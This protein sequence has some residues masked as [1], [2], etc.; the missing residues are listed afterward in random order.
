MQRKVQT[1]ITIGHAMFSAARDV[2]GLR[3]RAGAQGTAS[4]R[5]GD[6]AVPRALTI[7]RVPVGPNGTRRGP[8]R[9][10]GLHQMHWSERRRY[11]REWILEVLLAVAGVVPDPPE[12]RFCRMVIT[13]HRQRLLDQDNAVASCKPVIDACRKCGLIAGDSRKW[14]DLTVDQVRDEEERTEI[15]IIPIPEGRRPWA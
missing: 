6:V 13:L 11:F 4:A 5:V 2:S 8:F 15:T 12:S 10:H 7:P 9:V 3:A 1:N 14:L